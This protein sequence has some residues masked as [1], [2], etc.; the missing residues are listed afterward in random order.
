MEVEQST[1]TGLLRI[2]E[3]GTYD[4]RHDQWQRTLEKAYFE[5]QVELMRST[6]AA[7]SISASWNEQSVEGFSHECSRE[8]EPVVNLCHDGP[9]PAQYMSGDPMVRPEMSTI[10]LLGLGLSTAP[11]RPYAALPAQSVTQPSVVESGQTEPVEAP[12][13]I[14]ALIRGALPPGSSVKLLA[15]AQGVH[16]VIRDATLKEADLSKALVKIRSLL[17]GAN[18]RLVAVTLNGESIWENQDLI[19]ASTGH[20]HIEQQIDHLY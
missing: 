19:M 11:G 3:K 12:R 6:G 5:R 10:S 18:Q 9:A 20:S 15:G 7:E 16:I 8:C 4:G 2:T 13:E 1:S 14:T 17:L